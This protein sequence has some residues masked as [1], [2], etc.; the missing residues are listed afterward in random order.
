MKYC[1][2]CGKEVE[3]GATF[4]PHCGAPVGQTTQQPAQ[5]PT[6]PVQQSRSNGMA[7]AGFICSFFF[8][9][10]G[11]IFS[12][13]GL[14][15]SKTLGGSGKGLAIAGIVISAIGF[16]ISIFVFFGVIGGVLAAI[17]SGML[18]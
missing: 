17:S 8:P 5:Q 14:N 15:K 3:D 12:I 10:L 9:I 13:I 1:P 6:Q 11:L 18:M 16:V 2:I 7:I 4:C